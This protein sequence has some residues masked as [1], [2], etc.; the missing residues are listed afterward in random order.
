MVVSGRARTRAYRLGA[1]TFLWIALTVLVVASVAPSSY[2]APLAGGTLVEAVTGDPGGLNPAITTAWVPHVVGGQIYNALIEHDFD[3]RPKPDLAERWT[4][5]SDGLTYTFYLVRNASWHDGTKFTSADV[6]YSFE[7]VATKHHPWATIYNQAVSSVDIPDD[8]TVVFRLKM[9]FSPLMSFLGMMGL[10]ILPKHL[11]QGTDPTTNPRNFENPVGTGPFVFREWVKGSHITLV[12]NEKYFKPGKPRL[13]RVVIRII[14][15]PQARVLAL[16]RGEIDY[17][18]V[19]LSFS[20]IDRLRGVPGIKVPM[21]PERYGG[22]AFG[23]IR[24]IAV[25]LRNPVLKKLRVRQALMHAMDREFMRQRIFFGVPAVAHSLI[26]EAIGWAHNPDVTKYEFDLE[27]ANKLLDSAGLPRKATGERFSLT[28][29]LDGGVAEDVRVAQVLQEAFKRVGITL[30]VKALDTGVKNNLEFRQWE[31]DLAIRA[32]G[33]GPDPAMASSWL[34]T[35]GIERV[36]FANDAGYSNP[37]VDQL[38]ARAASEVDQA[39]RGQLYKEIQAILARDLP[40]LPLMERPWLSAFRTT[41]T[42]IPAGPFGG[43]RERFD[44]VVC[45][46]R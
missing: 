36:D 16:E 34:T 12:K 24:G 11:Y 20:D 15:D 5:S 22:E 2:T 13:D 31:F 29:L 1:R 8:Y 26:T 42:G 43:A 4:I 28:L 40:Y 30:V 33:A 10:P 27:K 21:P 17:I 35:D 14:P 41:C 38:F 46:S 23:Q 7:N 3:F 18:P 19:V 39:K 9:P 6:K 37:K 25:N 44:D 32:L 45:A